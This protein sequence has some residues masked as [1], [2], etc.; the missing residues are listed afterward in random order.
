MQKNGKL[1]KVF[2][3]K[4]LLES[5]DL[6]FLSINECKDGYRRPKSKVFIYRK[7]NFEKSKAYTREWYRQHHEQ[8][9]PWSYI[10]VDFYF[11]MASELLRT[12]ECFVEISDQFHLLCQL[13]RIKSYICKY[14]EHTYNCFEVQI[15]CSRG[16]IRL[17]LP[18]LLEQY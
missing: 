13:N 6:L 9:F 11:F 8:G 4:G 2:L 5:S 7:H 15:R 18:Y 14:Q 16:N 1:P 17:D 12:Q 3:R 10:T